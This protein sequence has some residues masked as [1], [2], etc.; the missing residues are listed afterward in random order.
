MTSSEEKRSSRRWLLAGIAVGLAGIALRIWLYQEP[1]NSDDV[2][3]FAVA[4]SDKPGAALATTTNANG[5]R[6]ALLGVPAFF[7]SIVGPS[8]LAFYAAVYTFAAL[9]FAGIFAFA[10]ALSGMRVA[11]ITAAVWATGY[12]AIHVDTRLTPDNLG[13]ALALLGLALIVLAARAGPPPPN[14]TARPARARAIAFALIGGLLLWAAFSARASFF[15][16]GGVGVMFAL[17]SPRRWSITGLTLAGL[18]LGAGLELL[19]FELAF[20]EPLARWKLLLGYGADVAVSGSSGG[21]FAGYSLADLFVRYPALLWRENTGET[22]AHFI[23]LG[24][25]AAWAVGWHDRQKLRKALCALVAYGFIAFAIVSIDPVIPL[26]REKLRYYATAA[27]L[28]YLATAEAI[29]LVVFRPASIAPL[30]KWPNVAAYQR[31]L[32][33]VVV[34]AL[35][36][37]AIRV[38]EGVR[39]AKN[40]SNGL[41]SA[42]KFIRDHREA[43]P[44]D[45]S[46]VVY[47]DSRTSRVT[48]ILLPKSDGWRHAAPFPGVQTTLTIPREGY[49]LL[50]WKRLN[51]NVQR[52]YLHAAQT[53]ALYRT[54]EQYPVVGRHHVGFDN[55][56][57]LAV[58]E[59]P[60]ARQTR[61]LPIAFPEGWSRQKDDSWAALPADG[62]IRFTSDDAFEEHIFTGEGP[63]LRPLPGPGL[64]GD[65]IIEAV[66]MARTDTKETRQIWVYLYWWHEE[67]KRRFKQLMGRAYVDPTA[68]ELAFWTYLPRAARSFKIAL[69][70]E[71]GVV[72]SGAKIYALQPHEADSFQ[73]RGGAW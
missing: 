3:Y 21:V 34:V 42:A 66:V 31:A 17:L 43:R 12:A 8:A 19:Y 70:A 9:S 27:P 71:S 13:A 39:F 30:G 4:T 26:M 2:Q 67:R 14:T 57:V 56:D 72:L 54:V 10:W 29:D 15:V 48:G 55:V 18:A 25:F 49:L 45:G 53:H 73:Q 32:G 1:V 6:L 44:H 24:V 38:S 36:F 46:Q 59:S 33:A 28:F 60:I 58:G 35:M 64:D 23:G 41:F 16:F 7:A 68:R 51:G 47:T 62:E 69:N 61:Q 11:F 37:N 5:M 40:G 65:Q 52:Q 22:V 50:S 63:L 20:D